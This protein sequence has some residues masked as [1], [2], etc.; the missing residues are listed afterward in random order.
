ML[1]SR[2][3]TPAFQKLAAQ[4]IDCAFF[5]IKILLSTLN[6]LPYILYISSMNQA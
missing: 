2:V 1:R 4:Q 3:S 5:K 6:P